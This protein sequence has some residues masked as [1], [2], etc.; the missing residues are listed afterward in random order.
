MANI[1]KPAMKKQAVFLCDVDEVL[2]DFV[3]PAIDVIRNITGR[4]YTRESFTTWGLEHVMNEKEVVRYRNAINLPGHCFSLPVCPFAKDGIKRIEKLGVAIHPVTAPWFT[5][6]TW[7]HERNEWLSKHFGFPRESIVHTASK[8]LVRGD[9]FLDDKPDNV[10]QW[11]EANP[12]GKS[13]LWDTP[14]NRESVVTQG[15][16]VRNWDDVYDIIVSET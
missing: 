5:G 8:H 16:R 4:R 3:G 11:A 13:L 1:I 6:Q 15:V 2:A 14:H 7:M 10:S 12:E 9:F